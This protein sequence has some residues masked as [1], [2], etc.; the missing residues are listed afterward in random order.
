MKLWTPFTVRVPEPFFSS[1]TGPER[2]AV[3]EVDCVVV[4][5][6]SVPLDALSK[7]SESPLAVQAAE[8]L[9]E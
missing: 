8:G 3:V 9:V 2:P 4:V 7:T 6:P 1:E 5:E